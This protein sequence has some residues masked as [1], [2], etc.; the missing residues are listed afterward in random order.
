MAQSKSTQSKKAVSNKS[1]R[2]KTPLQT[3]SSNQGPTLLSLPLT[4]IMVGERER[5]FRPEHVSELRINIEDVGLIHPITVT[6]SD[7]GQYRL[8]AGRHRLEAF[9]ALSA[10][11]KRSFSQIPAIL[12]AAADA[13]KVELCENLYRNDLSVLEKA[14]HL[15]HYLRSTTESISEAIENLAKA[16]KQ[17]ERTFF[18][19]KAIGSGLQVGEEIKQTHPELANS[20]RQLYF[21]ATQCSKDEQKAVLKLLRKHPEL[22]VQQ[23]YALISDQMPYD[24]IT[25]KQVPVLVS[26]SLRNQLGSLSKTH[27]MKKAEFTERFLTAAL[28]AYEEGTFTLP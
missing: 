6:K 23:A 17:S 21:L 5:A 15:D 14:E 28:Q 24:K 27:S 3:P 9:R 13:R 8:V 18:R 10:A 7:A 11:G 12:I 22:T 25:E 16:A 20:T 26:Q 19:Y 2:A 4:A 1:S